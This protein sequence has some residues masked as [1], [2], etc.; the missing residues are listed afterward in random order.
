MA[1]FIDGSDVEEFWSTIE[2]NLRQGKVR[3]V[4]VAD[5]LPKELVR[6]PEFLNEQMK[7]AEVL[8]VE[9]AGDGANARS[10]AAMFGGTRALAPSRGLLSV[11]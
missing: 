11:G 9:V 5:Q 10:G 1:E 6:I 3:M 2:E 8:G 4:F 7:P